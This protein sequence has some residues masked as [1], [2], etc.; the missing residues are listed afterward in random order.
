MNGLT[1]L[2]AKL[3]SLVV[4]AVGVAAACLVAA[5][6]GCPP[7]AVLLMAGTLGLCA[8]VA[9]AIDHLRTRRFYRTMHELATELEHP[10]QLHSLVGEPLAPDQ[11]IVF[12]A[13]AAMGTAAA[14]EVAQAEAASSEHRE[15]V[16]GWVHGIK[17]PLAA[18]ALVAERVAEPQRSQ[19][20]SEL[21]R[22]C[23]RVDAALWYAR[24]DCAN[25]DYAIREVRLADIA[26]QTCR[27]NARFLIEQGCQPTIDID[28]G[29]TVLTDRKQAVFIVSQLV[30]NAAKYGARHLRFSAELLGPA[31]GSGS[32]ALHVADDGRGIPAEEVDRVFERGFTGTRG[33]E[34]T[35]STGMGL[36]LAARLCEQLGL[37]LQ[38]ASVDGEGTRAT[39]SFPL[40]RRRLDAEGE[41]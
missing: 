9:A 13:L 24:A 6:C 11:A 34:G 19:L 33:R 26:R 27:D 3:P 36:Y 40:D 20:A 41:R 8:A 16:E 4:L 10:Y 7:D 2:Q 5:V 39:V 30:E 12:E 31:D 35:A 32:I 38:I 21:D 25:R 15:F 37:G 17:A 28:D 1:Y 18:C 22:I 23:H 14:A 29:T